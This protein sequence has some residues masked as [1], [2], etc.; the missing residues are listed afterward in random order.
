MTNDVSCLSAYPI[1][2]KDVA[3]LSVHMPG[4][5]DCGFTTYATPPSAKP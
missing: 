1:N 2:S 3:L 4:W 5:A